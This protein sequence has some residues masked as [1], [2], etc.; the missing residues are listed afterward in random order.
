MA[1]TPA[2]IR[3]L[4]RYEQI[5]C[6]VDEAGRGPWAGP[7]VVS[8]VVLPRDLKIEGLAD[9]K[10]LSHKVRCELF[11]VIVR[12]AAVSTVVVAAQRVDTMNI[13]GATLWGMRR[14]VA[15]LPL[16]PTIA[17]IDGRDVPG[18]LCVP[19]RALVGGDGRSTAIGAASIV[20]KVTR[21]RLMTQLARAFPDYGF[22]RHKGYGTPE[23][24]EALATHGP[25]I[26]HRR[27][28]APVRACLAGEAPLG[29]IAPIDAAGDGPENGTV[30]VPR[31]G[32]RRVE[33]TCGD[34]QAG[35]RAAP[36]R[37]GRPRK[38]AGG[39]P[40]RG[41]SAAYG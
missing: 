9:S 17:L 8:A 7:V 24:R 33:P 30:D 25:C 34:V 22:E 14:A 5:V 40:R 6:G 38:Y 32:G 13:R 2:R 20:A 35:A 23:H 15:T 10:L 21:D 3:A 37:V 27:S 39:R 26:H 11:D 16:R 36:R 29:E 28:F 1:L 19:G 41:A 4:S 18:D 12:E 31:D